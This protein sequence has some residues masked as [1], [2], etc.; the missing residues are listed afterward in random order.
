MCVCCT[1]CVTTEAHQTDPIKVSGLS[2]RYKQ[3]AVFKIGQKSNMG[4]NLWG[5]TFNIVVK[6]LKPWSVL[7]FL[8]NF[9]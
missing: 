4:D 8:H 7:M 9:D 5:A 3:A 6:L 1:K 2:S